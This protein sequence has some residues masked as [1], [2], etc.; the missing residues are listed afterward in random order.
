MKK[1]IKYTCAVV[2]MSIFGVEPISAEAY[3]PTPPNNGPGN[4]YVPSSIYYN[5]TGYYGSVDG[6]YYFVPTE[7]VGDGGIPAIP[8][9][10]A[11]IVAPPEGK[12]KYSGTFVMPESAPYYR[13]TNCY[14]IDSGRYTDDFKVDSILRSKPILDFYGFPFAGTDVTEIV[15]NKSCIATGGY[16]FYG[17][18]HTITLSFPYADKVYLCSYLYKWNPN[19]ILNLKE[20]T[21]LV[22]SFQALSNSLRKNVDFSEYKG[23][24]ECQC[25]DGPG[26]ESLTVRSDSKFESSCF[27]KCST[28]KKVH[29]V[30]DL[31]PANPACALPAD[32]FWNM[33]ALETFIVDWTTPPVVDADFIT[34]YRPDV[35]PYENVTV[36]VPDGSVELYRQ[37]E[38]W[39]N[40]KHILPKSQLGAVTDITAEK[41]AVSTRVYDLQGRPADATTARGILI[42]QT[43]WSDGTVTTDK[44]V[45]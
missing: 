28:L 1:Y 19:L 29:L 13:V 37:A 10:S 26:I 14:D 2:L 7:I 23:L 35:H 16:D 17:T 4:L 11:G 41:T 40:Y 36:Y 6:I 44:L 22:V 31:P 39:K 15:F 32:A 27:N 24:Y 12:P 3:N 30:G 5:L 21:E 33:P 8:L 43:T 45:R 9:P 18:D 20:G 34:T 38:V 25:L 42:K